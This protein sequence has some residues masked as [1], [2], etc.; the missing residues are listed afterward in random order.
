M[1]KQSTLDGA[2]SNKYTPEKHYHA[3]RFSRGGIGQAGVKH[4]N[5][6]FEAWIDDWQWSSTNEN[7][8]PAT[9]KFS[10]EGFDITLELNSTGPLVFHGDNGFSLKSEQGQASYYYSQPHIEVTANIETTNSTFQLSGKGWL[11]REWSTEALASDQE[12]W[13]WFS[14]HLTDGR[15][16]MLYQLRHEDGDHHLSGSLVSSDGEL[17]HLTANDLQLNIINRKTIQ[18]EKKVVNDIPLEWQITLLDSDQSWH[19]KPLYEKQWMDTQIPYWEGIV[20]AIDKSGKTNAIG[21]M[22]LTGYD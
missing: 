22:E 20:I 18:L 9:V 17:M 15:K 4:T 12:G 2:C 11:D 7:L 3:Q 13:D 16:L 21:Y 5:Q 19:I 10:V 8:F 1:A 14:L 6:K